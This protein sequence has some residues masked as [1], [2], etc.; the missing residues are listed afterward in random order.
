MFAIKCFYNIYIL[1]AC[2][3]PIIPISRSLRHLTLSR[4]GRIAVSIY[5]VTRRLDIRVS[6]LCI[7]M[8]VPATALRNSIILISN[9]HTTNHRMMAS[10]ATLHPQITFLSINSCSFWAIPHT[11]DCGTVPTVVMTLP[12]SS[13]YRGGL[14]DCECSPFARV[15][16]CV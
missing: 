13:S 6:H 4:W 5:Y 3:R 9:S 12:L 2:H 1:L 14:N 16:I 10:T 8:E 11:C 15:K 7:H